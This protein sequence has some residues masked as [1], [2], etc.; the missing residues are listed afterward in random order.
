LEKSPEELYKERIKRV[1]DAVYMRVPDRVPVTMNCGYLPARYVG[2]TSEE[3]HYNCEKWIM[4]NR[5]IMLDFQ[6]DMLSG[7]PLES[8]VAFE[9]IDTKIM[10]WPGH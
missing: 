3:A 8:G 6:P 9:A 7:F 4:A 10:K 2:M 1:E 5:K